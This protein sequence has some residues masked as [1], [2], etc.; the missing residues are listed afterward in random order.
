MAKKGNNTAQRVYDMI[1]STVVE[2]GVALWDVRFEKEGANWILRVIIDNPSGVSLD[3]CEKVS[4]AIDPILDEQ[5]PIDQSYFLEV[6]SPGIERELVRDEHFEAY[7][8]KDILVKLIRPIDD[9]REFEGKLEKYD[10]ATVSISCET[11]SYMFSFDDCAHI[12]AKDN[13]EK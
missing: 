5:D 6:S 3:D 2:Q 8:G 12:K 1:A 11:E 7:I 4:R 9:V 10:D 13:T